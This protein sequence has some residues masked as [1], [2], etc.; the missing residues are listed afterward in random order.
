MSLLTSIMTNDVSDVNV[1]SALCRIVDKQ[2][3]AKIATRPIHAIEQGTRSHKDTNRIRQPLRAFV[4]SCEI[5]HLCSG[6]E[7]LK[8][9][10]QTG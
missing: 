6:N 3:D 4:S 2:K 9:Q 5:Q 1:A 10:S 7:A 8:R